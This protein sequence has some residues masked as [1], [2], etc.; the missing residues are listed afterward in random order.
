MVNMD[1]KIVIA[2]DEPITRMD[3]REILTHAGYNVV[4]EASDGFD[5]V[6][7]CRK[8]NPDMVLLDI[9]MPLLDGLKAARII[10]EEHLADAI[11]LI[12]AYSGKEFVDQAKET[13]VVGYVVKPI[14]EE[15]LIPMVEIGIA[16]GK[17]MAK[18]SQEVSKTKQRLEDRALIEKA[19]GL[20]M[21]QK[22]LSEDEAFK[23]IRKIGMDKRRPMRD[24]AKIILLNQ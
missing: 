24:I 13:G 4:G 17:E 1:F 15:S 8:E 9:K 7:L 10:H 12:T 6:E 3:I 11:L 14:R 19:K 18:M 22:N 5:A 16:K 23:M 20:L 21:R 2:D